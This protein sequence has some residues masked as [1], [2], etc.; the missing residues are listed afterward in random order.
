MRK[1][2]EEDDEGACEGGR[3]R[4]RGV[5]MRLRSEAGLRSD[6]GDGGSSLTNETSLHCRDGVWPTS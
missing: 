3:Q 6:E 4:H 2:Q 5:Q 1:N